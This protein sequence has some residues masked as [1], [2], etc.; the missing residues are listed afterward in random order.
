MLL[1]TEANSK[2]EDMCTD[3]EQKSH[4]MHLKLMQIEAKQSNLVH[5]LNSEKQ[6]QAAATACLH[7]TRQNHAKETKQLK[8][9]ARNT[10]LN[11]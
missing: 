8:S 11:S 2:I 1:A 3:T 7:Q 5:M 4:T 10:P 6:A 9:Q